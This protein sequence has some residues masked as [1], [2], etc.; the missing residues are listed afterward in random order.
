MPN[1]DSQCLTSAT[2]P[3]VEESVRTG[4][5]TKVILPIGSLEQHGPHL[6]LST[7]TTI[8]DYVARQVSNRCNTA[9]LLPSIQLGC[10]SEHMGFPGTVFLKPETMSDIIL[11]ISYSLMKSKLTKIF[12]INGHGGNRATIDATIIK[13]KQTFPQLDVYSFTI[14]DIVKQKFNEIRKSGRRLV[15]H[16][17]EIE[18]SIMLAIQPEIVDM[19]KAVRE[20]PSLPK[21]LSFESEDI[22]KISFAWNAR[23]LTKSG[24]IGDALLASAETGK[25]LLDFATEIISKAINQL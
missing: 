20:E 14:I 17:D 22:A 12:I 8:A 9:F 16:A 15:G 7:D 25:I 23:E 2:W 13:I 19:S 4:R 18:T 6:P 24:V 5:I 21:P 11:D 10:A 1:H 3:E